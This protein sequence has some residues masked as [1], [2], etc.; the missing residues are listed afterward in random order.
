M[1]NMS[2]LT[3]VV[4]ESV[5]LTAFIQYVL[6]QHSPPSTLVVCSSKETFLKHLHSATVEQSNVQLHDEHASNLPAPEVSAHAEAHPKQMQIRPWRTPTLRLL[7]SSRTVKLAFCPEVTHLRAYL[8][9]YAHQFSK[10]QESGIP[11]YQTADAVRL[12]A[13]LNAVQLHRPTSAFSAQGLNRTLSIA[14][15]AAYQ[16]TSRLVLAECM[17]EQDT[18]HSGDP[19][20]GDEENAPNVST[21]GCPWDEEVSILNVTTKTFGAWGR[22]WVGR[23]VKIRTIA[24][25]WCK[26]E[27]LSESEQ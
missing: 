24:E 11:V 19:L 26:F 1:T 12:L 27:P 18:L 13:I 2:N 10:Q 15:E 14:V 16:T 25:R 21:D 20:A 22:G 8:A 3:P 7:V 17:T 4:L 9:S 23:T 6:D 5:D